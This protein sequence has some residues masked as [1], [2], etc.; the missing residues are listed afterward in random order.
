MSC[1]IDL[2]NPCWSP[3]QS[4][5]SGRKSPVLLPPVSGNTVAET[6]T[7]TTLMSAEENPILLPHFSPH[8]C[9]CFLTHSHALKD[10]QCFRAD[11]GA[12][13][14]DGSKLEDTMNEGKL[15]LPP[16]IVARNFSMFQTLGMTS[17]VG[18]VLREVPQCRFSSFPENKR[19][20]ERQLQL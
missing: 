17:S 20:P 15:Y 2:E 16:Q 1:L 6:E 7:F 19:C 18:S 11:G 9:S 5:T 10:S 4:W 14:R 12:S 3:R 8:C 13:R